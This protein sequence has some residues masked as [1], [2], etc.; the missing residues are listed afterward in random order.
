MP[1]F[2]ETNRTYLLILLS[3]NFAAPEK[4]LENTGLDAASLALKDAVDFATVRQ[5][6]RNLDRYSADALWPVRLGARIG[7]TGHGSVG[8]A[9]LSADTLG[10]AVS[11]FLD[12]EQ[13]RAPWYTGEIVETELFMEILIRDAMRDPDF[14]RVFF[15]MFT[16]SL[17]TLL[18]T[19]TR[20]PCHGASEIHFLDDFGDT[21]SLLRDA[22]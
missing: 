11:T 3:Q 16:A 20:A 10:Q 9:A 5:V 6:M 14:Q 8:F 7:V 13:I 2:R 12:W 22:F 4:V 18:S 17:E 1:L 19:I 21:E 15:Q